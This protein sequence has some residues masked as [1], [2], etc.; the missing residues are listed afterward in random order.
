MS[1]LYLSFLQYSDGKN[2]LTEISNYLEISLKKTIYLFNKLK[3]NKL[4]Y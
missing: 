2:D 4:I 3:R 1:K